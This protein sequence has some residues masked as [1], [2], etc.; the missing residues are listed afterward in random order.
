M[1]EK[2]DEKEPFEYDSQQHSNL[3]KKKPLTKAQHLY[4]DDWEESSS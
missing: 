1:S 2:S 3:Y 4:G